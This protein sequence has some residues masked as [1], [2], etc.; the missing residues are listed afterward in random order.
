MSGLWHISAYLEHVGDVLIKTSIKAKLEFF[1]IEV[2]T[3][4]NLLRRISISTNLRF[5]SS[6]RA[7]ARLQVETG[8]SERVSQEI[9]TK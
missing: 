7:C 6:L 3:A 2:A 5:S 9:L 4:R 8:D 1:V